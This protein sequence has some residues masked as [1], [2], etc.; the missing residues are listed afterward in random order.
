[1]TCPSFEAPNLTQFVC[2]SWFISSVVRCR[3]ALKSE[4][5]NAKVETYMLVLKLTID[6]MTLQYNCLPEKITQAIESVKPETM[7]QQMQPSTR[8]ATYTVCTSSL[9]MKL[10]CSTL[11]L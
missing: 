2:R 7:K 5:C 3:K 4:L 9:V 1:M 10:Y 6:L 11:F 8:F